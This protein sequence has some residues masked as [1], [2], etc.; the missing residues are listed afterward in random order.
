MRKVKTSYSLLIVFVKLLVANM[1][2]SL[3]SSTI[4]YIAPVPPV[5]HFLQMKLSTAHFIVY[6]EHS[7]IQK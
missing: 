5:E 1:K 7:G 2:F 4:L 3:S 6:I